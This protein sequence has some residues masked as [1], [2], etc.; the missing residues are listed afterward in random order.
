M[1]TRRARRGGLALPLPL[2]WALPGGFAA[3]LRAFLLICA[4]GSAAVE[5]QR[6]RGKRRRLSSLTCPSEMCWHLPVSPSRQ[7]VSVYN[8]PSLVF[9]RLTQ[10][11]WSR[12]NP[13]FLEPEVNKE[14]YQK[15]LEELSEEE[16][17][18]LE[19]K[20]VQP[21]KAAPPSVS[22]SVFSDPMIRSEKASRLHCCYS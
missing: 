15:P 19:L 2:A 7:I 6:W 11:R 1:G 5:K 12:Y 17:E 13:S 18:K 14:L 3:K 10:V 16:K 20:A 9:C 21:I 4:S 22:S 8:P